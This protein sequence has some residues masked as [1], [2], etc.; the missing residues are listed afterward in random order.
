ML[1]EEGNKGSQGAWELLGEEVA[2][3]E[4]Q[5]WP[6]PLVLWSVNCVTDPVLPGGKGAG[7]PCPHQSIIGH[8]EDMTS[9]ALPSAK[10][11]SLDKGVAVSHAQP[12]PAVAV[13]QTQWSGDRD[14][15][16]TPAVCSAVVREGF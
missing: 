5:L 8:R 11:N 9:Q 14:Q 6:V 10:D 13:R 2:S 3:G 7:A 12:I 1:W 16:G 4:V 15:G